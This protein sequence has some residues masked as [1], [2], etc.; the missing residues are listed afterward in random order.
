MLISNHFLLIQAL[1]DGDILLIINISILVIFYIVL[2]Y[3]NK[4]LIFLSYFFYS[5]F[6]SYFPYFFYLF[7]Y[8]HIVFCYYWDQKEQYYGI[9][10]SKSLKS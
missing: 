6:S 8:S 9:D 3:A 10:T 2:I 4:C 7:D 5:L 1:V